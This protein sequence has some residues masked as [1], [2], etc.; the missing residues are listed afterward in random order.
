[1]ERAAAQILAVVADTRMKRRAPKEKGFCGRGIRAELA[2]AERGG[3]QSKEH[4]VSIRRHDSAAATRDVRG[5][6]TQ[7]GAG[8]SSL[9]TTVLWMGRPTKQF[10]TRFLRVVRE[11]TPVSAVTPYH[12]PQRVSWA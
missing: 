5:R 6:G 3:S 1:V 10:K 2:G 11:N 9:R 12:K 7:N 8:S 4:C